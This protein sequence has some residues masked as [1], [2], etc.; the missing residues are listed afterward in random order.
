MESTSGLCM[1]LAGCEMDGMDALLFYYLLSI[2]HF[3]TL[4]RAS[5]TGLPP[6]LSTIFVPVNPQQGRGGW[7]GGRT[8]G[9]EEVKRGG[10]GSEEVN[11]MVLIWNAR[12]QCHS[13]PTSPTLTTVP[14][15]H[16]QSSSLFSLFPYPRLTG[17][18]PPFSL[19]H[20]S[21]KGQSQATPRWEVQSLL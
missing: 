18:P 14:R 21:L 2:Y 7:V 9:R 13:S 8:D 17:F 10:E 5:V 12:T 20:T 19:L 11:K 15:N 16:R 3:I 4:R 1:K 6:R